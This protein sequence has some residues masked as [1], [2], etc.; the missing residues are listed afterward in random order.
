MID[1]KYAKVIPYWITSSVKEGNG[2]GTR[3]FCMHAFV[4]IEL[5]VL[6]AFYWFF[7]CLFKRIEERGRVKLSECARVHNGYCL[8]IRID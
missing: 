7:D 4:V 3:K 6:N 8:G 5:K 2:G 1:T